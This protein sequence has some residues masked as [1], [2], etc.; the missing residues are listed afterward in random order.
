[1][2]YWRNNGPRPP[3]DPMLAMLALVDVAIVYFGSR[4]VCDF[5]MQFVDVVFEL[6][7]PIGRF[8]HLHW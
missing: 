1:M 3:I 4:W 5:A 7:H 8:G 2:W 6:I